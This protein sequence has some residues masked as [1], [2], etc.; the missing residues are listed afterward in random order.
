MIYFPEPS[1][2]F[3][4]QVLFYLS[5][6]IVVFYLESTGKF[7]LPYSKFAS[8]EGISPRIGMF[9]I[10]F[11]PILGYAS[12]VPNWKLQSS[13]Q[14]ILFL[15]FT[16]HFAKRCLEVLFL[17]QFS[18]KIGIIGVIV[19][20][21]AYTNIGLLLGSNHA[22]MIYP[23]SISFLDPIF[24]L[25]MLLFSIGQIGNFYHHLILKKLRSIQQSNEYTI[26]KGALF[27]KVICPHYF[28]E[29]VSWLGIAVLSHHWESYVIFFLMTCYLFG[30]STR[31]LSWYHSKFKD[32]P[33]DKK[34][35]I[36]YIY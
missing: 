24:M 26:P 13:Y 11:I 14:I 6:G 28:F 19:I 7:N 16:F 10:Y 4:I 9:I 33:T 17:H 20:T 27:D 18:G 25:G 5:F 31:T 35:I 29:L 12:T 23:E 34:R 32:F 8:S 1:L 22:K 2:I 21:L 3:Y 30:R 36:P 15:I